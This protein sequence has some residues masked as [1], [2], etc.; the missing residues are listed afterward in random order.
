MQTMD[1][2]HTGS[3]VSDPFTAPSLLPSNP[4]Q[5]PT[6]LETISQGTCTETEILTCTLNVDRS[7]VTSIELYKRRIQFHY[8]LKQPPLIKPQ[9]LKFNGIFPV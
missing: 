7:K 4:S 2:W 1:R 3:P 5:L 6:N 9:Y 8:T